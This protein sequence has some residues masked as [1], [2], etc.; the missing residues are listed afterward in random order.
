MW[1]PDSPQWAVLPEGTPEGVPRCEVCDIPMNRTCACDS[2]AE[3]DDTW[4]AA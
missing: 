1:S 4:E 3:P 2:F